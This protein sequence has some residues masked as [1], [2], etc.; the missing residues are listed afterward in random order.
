MPI[1]AA[2][3]TRRNNTNKLTGVCKAAFQTRDH[4]PTHRVEKIDKKERFWL[5]NTQ[6]EQLVLFYKTNIRASKAENK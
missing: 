6:L 5:F 3:E 2:R 1:A 4:S